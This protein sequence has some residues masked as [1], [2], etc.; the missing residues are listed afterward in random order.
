MMEMPLVVAMIAQRYRTDLVPGQ[1]V[2]PEF[3][4]R[5]RGLLQYMTA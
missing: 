3:V 4:K 1:V 2:F 5:R